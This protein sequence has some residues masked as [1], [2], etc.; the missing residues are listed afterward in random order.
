MPA[1]HTT[2]HLQAALRNRTP[3]LSET[4]EVPPA[5][6]THGPAPCHR[7]SVCNNKAL[8]SDPISSHKDA[9]MRLFTGRVFTKFT[10]RTSSSNTGTRS[11]GKVLATRASRCKKQCVTITFG[12]LSFTLLTKP[13]VRPTIWLRLHQC[14]HSCSFPT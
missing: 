14:R 1:L 11:A 3:R 5:A 7:T 4:L 2:H 6:Y 10:M 8:C 12:F 9:K 13:L